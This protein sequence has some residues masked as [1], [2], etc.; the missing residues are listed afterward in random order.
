VAMS[1]SIG[2]WFFWN[3]GLIWHPEIFEYEFS[4]MDKFL[5]IG[6]D[7]LWDALSNEECAK[8]VLENYLNKSLKK[9]A[10]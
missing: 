6:S 7:G 1:R 10:D 9:A 8:I 3:Y 5:V 2:D 4:E